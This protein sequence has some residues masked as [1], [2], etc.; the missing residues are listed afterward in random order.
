[1]LEFFMEKAGI[2]FKE[3]G[4]KLLQDQKEQLVVG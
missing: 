1:M 3:V 4:L 2:E